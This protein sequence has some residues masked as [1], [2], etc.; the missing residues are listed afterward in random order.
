MSNNSKALKYF[1]FIWHNFFSFALNFEP[2]AEK[3]HAKTYTHVHFAIFLSEVRCN[4]FFFLYITGIKSITRGK[5]EDL[6]LR[7]YP[8]RPCFNKYSD[9]CIAFVAA[10]LRRLSA[11]HQ[12]LRPYLTLSSLRSLPT[13]TSSLPH[14]KSGI[15]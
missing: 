6:P 7:N 12:R 10:P 14:A 9:I 1:I 11:T 5:R 2:A 15:G 8:I 3:P 4:I 13:K